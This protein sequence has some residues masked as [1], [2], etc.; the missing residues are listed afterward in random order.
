MQLNQ[1]EKR[2]NLILTITLTLIVGVQAGGAQ[3]ESARNQREQLIED[4]AQRATATLKGQVIWKNKDL[5]QTTVQVYRDKTLTNLYTG[6]TKIEGGRFSIKVEP[7]SYYV[8]A[9]VDVNRSG[10]FDDGD[11]MGILGIA[12]WR[13][14][15]QQKQLLK[16]GPQ[17]TVS[18]LMIHVTARNQRGKIVSAQHYRPDPI[19]QFRSELEQSSSG[20]NGSISYAT[21]ASV[22]KTSIRAYTDLSWKYLAAKSGVGGDG[23]FTLHLKP[24]K[25]Y[26]MVII[27]WNDSNL[28]DHGDWLGIHGIRSLQNRKAFPEPILVAANKFTEGVQIQISG[29]Q[30]ESGRVVPLVDADPDSSPLNDNIIE[31]SGK[32][33]WRGRNLD[34]CVLQVYVDPT[35]IRPVQQVGVE[36]DG[37][38]KLQLR[39]GD[40]YMIASVDADGNGQYGSGDGVGGYGTL[41]MS[42]RPPAA[43]TLKNGED[44]KIEIVVSAQYGVDGQLKPIESKHKI[45]QSSEAETGL[46]GRII[47]DG[48]DFMGGILSLS[49]TPTFSTVIP[50]ALDLKD[51]GRFKVSVPPGDYYVTA[52]ID[53]DADGQTGLKDGVGVYGTRQPVRGKPQLVSVFDDFITPHIDI[54]IFA[55]YVDSEGNIAEFEDGHRS[56]I[57]YQHGNPDDIFRFTRFGR[58]LEE[59]CYWTLGHRFTFSL[60]PT[61]WKLHDQQEFKPRVNQQQLAQAQHEFEGAEKPSDVHIA[62]ES[63]SLNVAFYYSYDGIIWEY[64]PMGALNPIGAG[65]NPTVAQNG[66]FAYLD[67]EGNVLGQNAGSRESGVLLNRQ[68]LAKE[69]VISPAGDYIAF[70]QQQINRQRIV[71]R[72]LAS[73]SEFL[74]PSTAQEMGTPSWSRNGEILA[75]STRGSIENVDSTAGRNIFAYDRVNERVEPIVIGNEDDA[76]PAWSPS[77]ANLV[78]FSRAEG[79]HRQ[80]WLIR[81]NRRGE[82]S[83]NQLTRHG[84]ENPVWLPD[85]STILYENNGQLWLISRDG[86]DTRPV[87]H[88]GQIMYGNDP[89]VVP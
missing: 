18:G 52:A 86:V 8:V 57:K 36:A 88:K 46:S 74:L 68:E 15:G 14:T 64:H 20:V 75:Y 7:G 27:D 58:E 60:T 25:Y 9:F 72:H 50:I 82:S 78:A 6:V 22:E 59:W 54:E 28:I 41:D 11:G 13:N 38:F 56:E 17:Q 16:V 24:G 2:F 1:S 10:K 62:L 39:P 71:I 73:N 37:N 84:G 5:S 85:G 32:V 53:V 63:T 77:D 80:I 76:D 4:F 21:R 40:Y 19:D 26:L 23:S 43:L 66:R 3:S 29:K 70:T 33:L 47:W 83:E 35:L 48:K 89:C 44:P 67:T 79:N 55:M 61:G 30:L 12:D 45:V 34:G 69:V 42:T 65:S 81:F 87:V 31:V 49:D 51:D